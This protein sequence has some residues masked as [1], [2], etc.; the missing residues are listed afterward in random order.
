MAVKTSAAVPLENAVAA[1]V[2]TGGSVD[3]TTTSERGGCA[4]RAFRDA[5]NVKVC[6][7]CVFS[8]HAQ[9]DAAQPDAHF[10]PVV[11]VD[12]AVPFDVSVDVSV[13][14]GGGGGVDVSV[15]VSDD[16]DV[17]ATYLALP[18]DVDVAPA[19]AHDVLDGVA[20]D[21]TCLALLP[22]FQ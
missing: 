5:N 13:V 4:D 19:F 2:Q 9:T 11:D 8:A 3:V 21:A 14:V 7:A 16:D 20:A 1:A 6:T 15:G 12:L 18:H 10:P 22:R 17:Y